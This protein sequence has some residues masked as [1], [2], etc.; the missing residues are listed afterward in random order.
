MSSCPHV[1]QEKFPSR[2]SLH[3]VNAERNRY[4]NISAFDHT[5]VVLKGTLNSEGSDYINANYIHGSTVQNQYV[6][7]Q[8]Y[9]CPWLCVLFS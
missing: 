4:R 5:R 6:A 8:G 1:Y 7:A 3:P 9:G 2:A